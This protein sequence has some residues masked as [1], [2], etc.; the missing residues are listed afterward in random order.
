M[1]NQVMKV[2]NVVWESNNRIPAS[3]K[4]PIGGLNGRTNQGAN[5]EYVRITKDTC[6]YI[7]IFI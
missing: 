5:S 1:L 4:M 7:P 6:V 2:D 3:E